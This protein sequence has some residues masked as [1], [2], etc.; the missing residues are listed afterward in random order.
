M[1]TTADAVVNSAPAIASGCRASASRVIVRARYFRL[2]RYAV[3]A[4]RS[5]TGRLPYLFGIGGFF[6]DFAFVVISGGLV[7]HNRVSAAL[8]FAPTPSSGLVLFPLPP[9]AWHS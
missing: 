4:S 2:C 7:I 6:V 5:P 9:I 1:K 3:S 8:S